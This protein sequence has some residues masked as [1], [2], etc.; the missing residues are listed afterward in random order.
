MFVGTDIVEVARIQS[1]IQR[2]GMDFLQRVFT[3][4][5]IRKINPDDID[6]ERASGFWAAKESIVKAVGLG[7]RQGILFH[8][9]EIE[10]DE[11]GCP[12]FLLTGKLKEIIAQKNITQI[13]L[14][15]S[16]C[17]THAVAVSIIS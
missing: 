12:R 17:R 7:F 16:H 6:Y 2:G 5:E 9:A 14:S 4:R 11:Y 15:I 10:H 8:D 1:A 3:H 13:A